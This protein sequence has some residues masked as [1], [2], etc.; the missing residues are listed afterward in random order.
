MPLLSFYFL[1][2]CRVK[3][4]EEGC[5][6]VPPVQP[7]RLHTAVTR[8]PLLRKRSGVM[9]TGWNRR[10]LVPARKD[11]GSGVDFNTGCCDYT[12]RSSEHLFSRA[13]VRCTSS[14][15]PRMYRS[16]FPVARRASRPHG[17]SCR[18]CCPGIILPHVCVKL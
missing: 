3:S 13:P 5:T 18:V 2:R 14:G 11:K 7:Q 6:L 4:S 17:S 15:V 9:D 16:V 10:W 8:C 1:L 12:L